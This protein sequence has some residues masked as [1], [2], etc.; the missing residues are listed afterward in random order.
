MRVFY[1]AHGSVLDIFYKL[2]IELRKRS[3]KAESAYLISDSSYYLGH[4]ERFP[5]LFKNKSQL[6]FEWNF[7]RLSETKCVKNSD[8]S[9][10]CSKY[11]SFN[12]W[13]ALVCDRR[14]TPCIGSVE[15]KLIMNKF[16]HEQLRS[17]ILH[18]LKELDDIIIRFKP[19]LILTFVPATYGDYLL[20]MIALSNG[21]AY[22]QMRSTKIENY[23]TFS[24]DIFGGSSLIEASYKRYRLSENNRTK[25]ETTSYLD[26]SEMGRIGYEGVLQNK[27]RLKDRLVQIFVTI[28]VAIKNDVCLANKT[29]RTDN[30][31]ISPLKKILL[32]N[33]TSVGA[34]LI[35]RLKIRNK[36]VCKK[37]LGSL[38]YFLYPMHSE[39]EI[40]L[41]VNGK[42]H[43]NQVELIR[44]IAQSLPIDSVLVVKEHPRSLGRRPR[45]WWKEILEIPNVY[46]AN[47]D[48][49]TYELI[50]WCQLVFTVSGF[51]GFEAIMAMRPVILFGE[52][53]YGILPST[54]V[55]K[56]KAD[57]RQLYT[58]VI[59]MLNTYS[60]DR[61]AVESYISA[62]I[63]W[64]VPINLYSTLLGKKYRE[65]REITTK[66]DAPQMLADLLE[67]G[68]QWKG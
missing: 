31:V 11:K 66:K 56:V 34:G 20:Y 6:L 62:N 1:G 68:M 28:G 41:S 44:T 43:M 17:I 29:I 45:G 55:K 10:I 5:M 67:A 30:H 49:T 12:L 27:L 13:D 26:K 65:S 63:D 54:M 36:S 7:T 4:V 37:Q 58:E 23:I 33:F 9:Q 38:D 47:T 52:T 53:G 61:S 2:D 15:S 3:N 57:K 14:L 18:T 46:V 60:F 51:I 39:P 32:L 40:A 42:N 16:S 21:I 35:A 24:D 25:V 50:K 59:E 8:Y 22:R 64:S 19:D 48:I